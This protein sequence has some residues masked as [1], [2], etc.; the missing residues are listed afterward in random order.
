MSDIFG[1]DNNPKGK[2]LFGE[3][4]D[5]AIN[6]NKKLQTGQA[7]H[8]EVL[9]ISKDE[10]FVSTGGLKDGVVDRKEFLDE[11]GQLTVRVGDH[12]QLYVVQTQGELLKLSKKMSGGDGA[13]S[14][15]DA[16]DF[17]QSVDGKVTEVCNGGFRVNVLG[18]TAFCPTSQMDDR[19]IQDATSYV[20]KKFSFL[21]TQFE[22]RGKNIVV[23]RRKLLDQ[24]RGERESAA[25]EDLKP[26][27]T[28]T[29][30]IKRL[31]KFGA[32]VEVPPGIEGLIHISEISWSRIKD[33][34]EVLSV[35]QSVQVKVLKIEEENGRVRLSLSIKQSEQDPWSLFAQ[36]KPEGKFFQ[37]KVVRKESFGLII[38]LEP[39]I[40][41]L[42]PVGK[43]KDAPADLALDKKK[44]GD[45]VPVVVENVRLDEKRISLSYPKDAEDLSWMDYK[46]S[47]KGFGSLA[48]QFAQ[49][50]KKK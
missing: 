19:P 5:Q 2:N 44:V 37:G 45:I 42:L 38:E 23:S 34:S 6:P 33:P 39:G 30:T 3:L 32:F 40:A 24:E 35:G 28:L 43:M 4:F 20:G 41:G 31:E 21:I 7:I 10:I 27:Q 36:N 1:D 11:Q 47:S 14:L 16:F 49:A 17:M 18:K 15:E 22:N 50:M 12:V 25:L 13:E 8:A 9:N 29:G 46:S 26:G 48:D